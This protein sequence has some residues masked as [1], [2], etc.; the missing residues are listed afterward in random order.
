MTDDARDHIKA[1]LNEHFLDRSISS[2]E[3]LSCYC[4]NS[5]PCQDY[6]HATSALELLGGR[7][8]D[9][10]GTLLRRDPDGHPTED[11]FGGATVHGGYWVQ[12]VDSWPH[13][14]L[15]AQLDRIEA[16]LDAASSLIISPDGE[17]G[18]QASRW[19]AFTDDELD[20]L[21][22][23]MADK[24]ENWEHPLYTELATEVLERRKP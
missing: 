13:G 5:W 24:L 3:D 11:H 14:R 12:L 15:Q 22:R 17:W 6:L 7:P 4:G 10:T 20:V 9:G 19:A 16:K 23:A 1:I 8:M 21:K 2:A 18:E